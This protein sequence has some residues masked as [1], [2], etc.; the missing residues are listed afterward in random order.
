MNEN[1][2]F[3]YNNWLLQG[4][5]WKSPYHDIA[6]STSKRPRSNMANLLLDCGLISRAADL[7]EEASAHEI[8]LAKAKLE[9]LRGNHVKSTNY[10]LEVLDE[11]NNSAQKRRAIRLLTRVSPEDMIAWLERHDEQQLLCR[12]NAVTQQVSNAEILLTSRS[13][14]DHL[15]VSNSL[16]RSTEKLYR[17]NDLWREM[18]LAPLPIPSNESAFDINYF[19]VS[20]RVLASD[21][22]HNNN[23]SVVM[24]VHNGAAYLKSSILSILNQL[25][26]EIEL[27][28]VD[29]GSTDDT[30]KII[31]KIKNLHPKRVR[32]IRLANN[33]GTYRAKNLALPMCRYEY[34]AFQDADDW[35]HPERLFRAISWLRASKSNVA[36]T[37]RYVRLSEEGSF[38]SPAVWP[39]RQWS[40]N[41]LVMRRKEILDNIGGFDTVAV[42]ADTDYFERIRAVFGDSRIKFQQEVM[43]VAMGLSTSLMHN[44]FTGVSANGYS[45]KRIAYREESAERILSAVRGSPQLIRLPY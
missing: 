2:K 4:G 30:W 21:D 3:L 29:D 15:L 27:I 7:I 41:T 8:L 20:E 26:V 32:C 40:P 38:Y 12:I 22:S 17:L 13:G 39:I 24:T 11:K 35:S 14:D 31:E 18:H 25:N 43:L 33:V 44:K 37:C 23:V 10:L 9:F 5:K 16:L 6:F 28:V 19:P 36:V 1:I 45:S 34:M 42:G